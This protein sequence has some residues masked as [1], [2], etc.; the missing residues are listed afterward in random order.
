MDMTLQSEL[1]NNVKFNMHKLILDIEE[2]DYGRIGM[3]FGDNPD[4]VRDFLNCFSE[5]LYRQ[6]QMLKDKIDLPEVKTR[7]A[8]AFIGDSITSDRES[9]MNILKKAFENE[10]NLGFIDAAVSGDK[11]DDARMKFYYR[12]MRHHPD[13]VHILLGTNDIRESDD[14]YGNTCV[15][16]HD[17]KMNMEY[18]VGTLTE[19]GIKVILSTISPVD[20]T[21]L[22]KRFP[23]DNWI[24]HRENMDRVNEILEEI[25]LKYQVTLN[26]MRPVYGK[27]ET[28]ELLLSDGLHL[29]ENGQQLLSQNVLK[30]LIQYL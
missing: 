20:N 6:A 11:S 18:M 9:F 13:I 14:K 3:V 26:D 7:K 28:K 29:N 27:F 21:G 23:D 16:L 24:Y 19:E 1:Y 25:S 15:S 22:K 30:S 5:N 4:K 8:I 10:T 17:Y 12:T 2:D